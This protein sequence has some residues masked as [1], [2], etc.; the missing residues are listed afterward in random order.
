MRK[1]LISP[2][3]LKMATH[4]NQ[5]DW[6]LLGI[7]SGY[8]ITLGSVRGQERVVEQTSYVITQE[9]K[10]REEGAGFPQLHPSEFPQ[11]HEVLQPGSISDRLHDLPKVPSGQVCKMST[12]GGHSRFKL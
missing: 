8:Q 5:A 12:Y 11:W 6:L 9:L 1:G 3:S 10:E 2:T 4:H 7:R